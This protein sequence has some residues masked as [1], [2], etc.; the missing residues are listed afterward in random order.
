MDVYEA[1]RLLRRVGVIGH[2]CDWTPE[3][4]FCKLAWVLGHTRSMKRIRELMLTDLVGEISERSD[5]RAFLA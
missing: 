5:P 3:T 2:G 1:G 4:A